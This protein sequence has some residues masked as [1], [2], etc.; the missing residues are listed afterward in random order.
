MIILSKI[1]QILFRDYLRQHRDLALE[2][3]ALKKQLIEKF[4]DGRQQY[5]DGKNEF[6]NKILTLA[7]EIQ[8]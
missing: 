5:G 7:E 1:T 2:Y 8:N 6:V 3:E 4:P